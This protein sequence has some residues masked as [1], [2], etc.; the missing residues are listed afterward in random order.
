MGRKSIPHPQD[1]NS[2]AEEKSLAELSESLREEYEGVLSEPI[3]ERLQMLMDALK[4]AEQ[5]GKD[6]G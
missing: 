5:K 4:E 1:K 2:D 3:P 6:E